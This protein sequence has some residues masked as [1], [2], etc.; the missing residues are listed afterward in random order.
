MTFEILTPTDADLT[1]VTPRNET[2][3]EDKVFAVSLG[4]RVTGPNTMLDIL[5]PGLRDALYK[6]V[7]GQ[8]Q[9][10]GVE[11]STPPLNWSLYVDCPKCEQS[12]E[13]DKLAGCDVTCEHCKHEFLLGGVE[14]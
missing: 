3:G 10:P 5:Q 1:S 12:N 13:C 9:L 7:D 11:P 8:E 6:P 14:Y 4:L 2:H